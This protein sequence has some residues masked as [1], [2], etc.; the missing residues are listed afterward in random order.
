MMTAPQLFFRLPS[1]RL[2]LLLF[3]CFGV[4]G[5][6]LTANELDG[7]PS[8]Y[9]AQHA[10]DP[11]AWRD[12]KE[13]VFRDAR[14]Q[15]RLVFVSVGYFSCHW[16]HVMQRESYQDEAIAKLLNDGYISV[17]IDREL[18]PD[19]DQRL[20]GFVEA[21]RGSAGWPLNVF[22]TPEGYPITGFTYLPRENFADVLGQLQTEWDV[23]HE[24][25]AAA[26][27][28]FF[29]EQMAN[30]GNEAFNAPQIPSAKLVDAFVAQAMLAADEMLGGFGNTSKFPNVPQLAGLLEA[31][32]RNPDIDP[33]VS[34][35]VRLTLHSMASRNLVDHVND[36]FFRYT[37]D[38]DWQTPHFEKMLYDNAQLAS[39]YLQA[40]QLWPDA[41]YEELALR[42]LDFAEDNLKH[43][44]G[45]YM[46]SLS[47]VDRDD[48]EGGAYWWQRSEL[49]EKLGSEDFAYV[50]QL[51]QTNSAD[52]E[53]LAGP[54]VGSAA[55]GDAERNQRIRQKL[56]QRDSSMPADDKRLASWNAMMLE[57]LT[58]ASDVDA[59]FERRAKTLYRDLDR[60]FY[61]DGELIRFAGNA[62]VAAA[63][64]EDYAQLASAFRRYGRRF[65]D[66]GALERATRLVER[67][68]TR[69]LRNGRWQPKAQ[70]LIPVAA[71][72]WIMPDLVFYSPMS[73]WL[74]SALDLSGLDA[75]VRRDA[76]QMLTRATREMLDSPYFY[77]SF[78][79]LRAAA[80][81]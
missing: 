17:K 73:L 51:W 7:H 69:F 28:R 80:D 54:L 19:L 39:L 78:I 49:S 35:F 27:R 11:V 77:G 65:E 5:T 63:V 26:A 68:H 76:E 60:L 10:G 23:N 43:P 81:A 64:F 42:T 30:D 31:V 40:A 53:F 1:A 24:K 41:G 52:S 45:G 25:L 38:P 48:R 21:I 47:A 12:W 18:E 50:E 46:S 62:E 9:L 57:A 67:A 44:D 2:S 16:C 6:S 3:L 29:D 34:D 74:E 37:T 20:I 22:M 33:D 58:R 61:L 36:G 70:P 72:K 8:P 14:A 66:K 32:R 4:F 75:D 59:R 15:N 79:M 13:D 55:Q 71:G 56:R